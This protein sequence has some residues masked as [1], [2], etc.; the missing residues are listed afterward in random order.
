MRR[1][2]AGAVTSRMAMSM[3]THSTRAC[4]RLSEA[5]WGTNEAPALMS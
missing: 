3:V 2:L 5:E 4:V 1:E